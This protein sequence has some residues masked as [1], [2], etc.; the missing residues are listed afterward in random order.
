LTLHKAL[1]RSV[2]TYVCPAWEFAADTYLWNCSAYRTRC[3]AILET[4]QGAQRPA[5]YI[6]RSKFHTFIVLLRNYAGH[7]S[8]LKP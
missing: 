1:I 4:T 7:R 8:H 3:F 6:W 2:M 5:I